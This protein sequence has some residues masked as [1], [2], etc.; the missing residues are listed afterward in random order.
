VDRRHCCLSIDAALG[1]DD[2][3][4]VLC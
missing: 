4:R 1:I 3:D 2:W